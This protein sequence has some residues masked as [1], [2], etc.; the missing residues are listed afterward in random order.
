MIL[1]ISPVS[2][3][4]VAYDNINSKTGLFGNGSRCFTSQRNL[5]AAHTLCGPFSNN[6]KTRAASR[7]P[8]L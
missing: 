4:L 5:V 8:P 2:G 7:R 1:R 3:R 6:R